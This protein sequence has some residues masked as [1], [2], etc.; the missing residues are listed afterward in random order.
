MPRFLFPAA[1]I[2]ALA[3]LAAADEAGTH[4]SRTMSLLESSGPD[5]RT[6]VSILFY[7]QSITA[8]GY[9]DRAIMKWIKERYPHA[10]VS[11]QNPAIGGY[12]APALRL[13]AWQDMY[14]RNPDLVVFHVYGGEGGELEEIFR[15]MRKHLT[16]DILVWTHHVDETA[17]EANGKREETSKLMETLAA[18]YGCEVADARTLWKE[19]MQREGSTPKDYIKDSIHLND[20]GGELLGQ[21]VVAR[22]QKSA[23]PSEA[24]KSRIRTV[25]LDRPQ[26]GISY[27]EGG[28]KVERGGL[29]SCGD[30]PLRI[31]FTGNRVDLI[32]LAG[33][34]GRARILLD[35]KTPSSL[36]D[37]LAAGRSTKTPGAWW[38]AVMKVTLG[39]SVVP[40][41]FSMKFHDVAP[42]GSAYAFDVTGSVTGEEGSGEK[43]KPFTA[44]SGAFSLRPDHLDISRVKRVVNK[45]LPAEFTVEWPVFSMSRDEWSSPAELAEGDV[46]QDTV[47]RCWTDG[48]H[49]LEI[50]PLGDGPVGIRE[51]MI[52]SPSGNAQSQP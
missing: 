30:K 37:T 39:D 34:G 22:F 42:D 48:P 40:Q 9:A 36:R 31:A 10:G 11:F 4:L 43:G 24:W 16:A 50:L 47:I 3:P 1:L 33:T 29:V 52:F 12:P 5:R 13:S 45:D 44:R 49:V 38:P 46:P 20:R 51:V 35:G 25:P 8:Q 19:T 14:N 7:G 17:D 2:C 28:W 15:G 27:E 18:K 21:A 32:G 26:P 23:S 6:P 41:T